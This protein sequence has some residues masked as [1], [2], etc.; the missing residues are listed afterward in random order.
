MH[1]L[2][3]FFQNVS[4]QHRS[5]ATEAYNIIALIDFHVKHVKLEDL[6]RTRIVDGCGCT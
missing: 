1:G 4:V 6:A 3:V 5:V 2:T